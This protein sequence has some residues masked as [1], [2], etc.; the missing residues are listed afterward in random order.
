MITPAPG[1]LDASALRHALTIAAA[2]NDCRTAAGIPGHEF[3]TA[4]L[5]VAADTAPGLTED[6]FVAAA[7]RAWRTML[8]QGAP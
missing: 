7:R 2:A 6:A 4:L 8:R 3:R 5:L 1:A